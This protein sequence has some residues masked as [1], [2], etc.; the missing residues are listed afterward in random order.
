MGRL[1]FY[2][3][4]SILEESEDKM[5]RHVLFIVVL[6]VLG[7]SC[8]IGGTAFGGTLRIPLDYPTIQAAIDAA[9]DGDTVMVS[10]GTYVGN[11][12]WP[13]TDNITLVSVNGHEVTVID[14]SGEQESCIYVG[15]G[16]KGVMINGFTIRNGYGSFATFHGTIRF[17]GGI[18]IDENVTATIINSV[19]VNNGTGEGEYSGGVFVSVG[20][21]VSVASC[22]VANNDATGIYFRNF[23]PNGA[24]KNCLITNNG[25]EATG[26]AWN[27]GGIYCQSSPIELH[28]NTIVHNNGPGLIF[29]VP[30]PTVNNNIIVENAGSAILSNDPDSSDLITHNDLWNN[31]GGDYIEIWMPWYPDIYIV[32]EN[33]NISSIPLFVGGDPFD[34]HLTENSSCIDTGT[35]VGAPDTD[36][37]GTARPQGDGYDIGACE[38]LSVIHVNIDIK[39]GSYPNCFN[40]N[41]KG[42]IPVAI[43]SDPDSGFDATQV[44][45]STV[46]L[47]GLSIKIAG[48]SD[49]LLAHIKDANGDGIS[50]LVT[51]IQD[52][53]GAFEPD[54]T[55]ATVTGNLY[56]EYGGAA[57][58]GTDEICIVPKNELGRD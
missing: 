55:M 17:G 57:I 37:D 16:Q 51:Q 9:T 43:L 33:G 38:F 12:V 21:D 19:I 58:E 1:S 18:L 32:G 44:D 13:Q 47:S 28:S 10:P 54:T 27:G 34:Y 23:A 5:K 49:K 46:K 30:W 31:A 50:D 8:F 29:Y 39:P 53:G 36:I 11:L 15:N 35:S 56:Q 48:K 24:I 2:A 14:G 52:S 40:N 4:N 20:S 22:I 45:P 41:G 7:V 26:S 6:G 42:V 25:V 3:S